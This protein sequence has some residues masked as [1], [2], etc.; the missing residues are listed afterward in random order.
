M[1][2]YGPECCALIKVY[3]FCTAGLLP[4]FTLHSYSLAREAKNKKTETKLERKKDGK[5][6]NKK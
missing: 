4:S 5:V 3:N 1:L 2:C 6:N